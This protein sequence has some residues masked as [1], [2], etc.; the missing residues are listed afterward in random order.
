M[1]PSPC[2]FLCTSQAPGCVVGAA[3]TDRPTNPP[4]R[5]GFPEGCQLPWLVE[6]CVGCRPAA[7]GCTPQVAGGCPGGLTRFPPS[8]G[9]VCRPM[10]VSWWPPW[11]CRLRCL[12]RLPLPWRLFHLRCVVSCERVVRVRLRRIRLYS[13]GFWW[14]PSSCVAFL[15]DAVAGASVC[16]SSREPSTSF[17]RPGLWWC[18][19]KYS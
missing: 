19:Q 2:Q 18:H 12:K 11:C 17:C 3:H 9:Q 8:L 14:W 16:R 4:G 13:G 15:L 6:V 1:R 5:I 7:Y 10:S